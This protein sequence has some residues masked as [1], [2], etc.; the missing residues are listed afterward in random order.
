M[1]DKNIIKKRKKLYGDS[2][3]PLAKKWS[4]YLDREINEIDVARMMAMLKIVRQ[5]SIINAIDERRFISEY[6][7][8]RLENALDDTNT[9]M[10]NYNWIANNYNEYK[11]L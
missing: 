5:D 4:E 6:E 11:R 3:S 7:L 9:D 2:F 10:N 1:V 8:L